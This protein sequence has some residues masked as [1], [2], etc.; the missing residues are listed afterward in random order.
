MRASSESGG[1]SARETWHR[2]PKST[3]MPFPTVA[4]QQL[5]RAAPPPSLV[6]TREDTNIASYSAGAGGAGLPTTARIRFRKV[7]VAKTTRT[8]LYTHFSLERQCLLSTAPG[9]PSRILLPSHTSDTGTI[10][11][12]RQ[13]HIQR[14]HQLA[15]SF[16][17][18]KTPCQTSAGAIPAALRCSGRPQAHSAR[19]PP[20]TTLRCRLRDAD[21]PALG[22]SSWE[23]R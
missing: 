18:H 2:T 11:S 6:R 12:R 10:Q 7:F 1:G 17:N 3:G 4:S 9:R 5:R 23:I 19:R 13:R 21:N 15:P 8:R 16:Q 14:A 20:S 22:R